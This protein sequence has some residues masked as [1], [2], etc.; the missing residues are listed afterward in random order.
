MILITLQTPKVRL[1]GLA[2]HLRTAVGVGGAAVLGYGGMPQSPGKP[3]GFSPL[4]CLLDRLAD[5]FCR[6][7]AVV[8]HLH[9]SRFGNVVFVGSGDGRSVGVRGVEE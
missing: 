8:F 5:A 3:A 6:K 4:P 9:D 7:L 1:V 2:I